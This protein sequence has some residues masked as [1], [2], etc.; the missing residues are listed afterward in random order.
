MHGVVGVVVC[1]VCCALVVGRVCVCVA[2]RC[3]L[4]SLLCVVGVVV[5][6]CWCMH[7]DVACFA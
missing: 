6:C 5:R 3:W 7:C 4:L 1:V 2:C